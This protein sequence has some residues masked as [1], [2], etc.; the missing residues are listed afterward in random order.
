VVRD[1]YHKD[2][3]ALKAKRSDFRPLSGWRAIIRQAEQQYIK[4]T[5]G[6][7]TARAVAW[8]VESSINKTHVHAAIR[9]TAGLSGEQEQIKLLESAGMTVTVV[10]EHLDAL[11]DIADKSGLTTEEAMT[12]VA[13]INYLRWQ[14]N[15]HTRRFIFSEDDRELHSVFK[16]LVEHDNKNLACYACCAALQLCTEQ[17]SKHVSRTI[18]TLFRDSA[19]LRDHALLGLFNALEGFAEY[20]I[21]TSDT[22]NVVSSH[23]ESRVRIWKYKGNGTFLSDRD[24]II[25]SIL[26]HYRRQ[27]SSKNM[28]PATDLGV[29]IYA[30][31]MLLERLPSAH[32]LDRQRQERCILVARAFNRLFGY[33]KAT[34]LPLLR[35]EGRFTDEDSVNSLLVL[36]SLARELTSTS[37][38][39]SWILVCLTLSRFRRWKLD[40]AYLDDPSFAKACTKRLMRASDNEPLSTALLSLMASRNSF[41]AEIKSLI[42]VADVTRLHTLMIPVTRLY[43]G[44]LSASAQIMVESG[45]LSTLGSR[46]Y[47]ICADSLAFQTEHLL[48][49]SWLSDMLGYICKNDRFRDIIDIN[50]L[51]SL[52]RAWELMEDRGKEGNRLRKEI[53][54]RGGEEFEMRPW[55]GATH[56]DQLESLIR[57]AKQ[58]E[59]YL[60]ESDVRS[61][62]SIDVEYFWS[63]LGPV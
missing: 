18:N 40:V 45:I 34:A 43:C 47:S 46:I 1:K 50:I 16:T 31:A 21:I 23:L 52:V 39:E 30:L 12:V 22:A 36:E 10:T 28:L 27:N 20:R 49:T 57:R 48:L 58:G 38:D 41:W 54:E 32:T 6:D 55:V 13:G 51:S 4:A 63:P 33:S 8:L 15:P 14:D 24:H 7:I 17:T 42:Q 29:A 5:E 37:S 60:S 35:E 19:M 62:T 26:W 9:A 2:G 53:A 11:Y 61:G 3:E 44:R 59:V 25:I 56:F